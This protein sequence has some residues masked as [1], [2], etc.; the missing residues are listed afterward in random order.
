M[1]VRAASFVVV[2]DSSTVA[3]VETGGRAVVSSVVVCSI[4]DVSSTNDVGPA[5]GTAV[6]MR[7]LTNM[8][9]VTT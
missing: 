2:V 8:L 4:V 3:V 9:N 7:L 6:V 1:A 5:E